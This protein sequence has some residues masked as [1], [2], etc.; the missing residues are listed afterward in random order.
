[1]FAD[2][3]EKVSAFTHPIVVSAHYFDG[4]V[5]CSLGAY[6]VLN[7][8]GWAITAAHLLEVIPAFQQHSKEIGEYNKHVAAIEQNSQLNAK[9]K[10][11]R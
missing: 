9:Q 6:I 8:D 2:A 1:M 7:P 5:R 11:Q 4:T 3:Y 10:R